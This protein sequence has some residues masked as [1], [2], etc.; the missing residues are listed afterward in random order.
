MKIDFLALIHLFDM[1]LKASLFCLSDSRQDFV[2]VL[3]VALF[4]D[5]RGL[6]VFYLVVMV[7]KVF[8][9]CIVLLSRLSIT[10]GSI[11]SETFKNRHR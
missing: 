1:L 8:H 11:I 2:D 4:F 3:L 10:F 5:L 6:E 7:D 9:S